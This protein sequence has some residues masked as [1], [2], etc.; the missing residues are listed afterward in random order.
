MFEVTRDPGVVFLT[1]PLGSCVAAF[2]HDPEGTISGCLCFALPESRLDRARA[3]A[4]PALFGDTGI[5]ALLDGMESAGAIR[6]MISVTLA[7]GAVTLDGGGSSRTALR[8]LQVARRTLSK[9]GVE[10]VK[11]VTGGSRDVAVL[12]EAASGGITLLRS[13][14]PE[15]RP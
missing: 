4:N 14:A 10:M 6:K 1:T 3:R 13:G 12:F 15:I 9:L 8:N 7:G 2:L 11:E 5:E